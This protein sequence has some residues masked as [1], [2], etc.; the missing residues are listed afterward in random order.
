MCK[1]KK[2]P[3]LDPD[4]LHDGERQMNL[5]D[6]PGFQSTILKPHL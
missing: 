6:T 4:L 3:I 5:G 2:T 1:L